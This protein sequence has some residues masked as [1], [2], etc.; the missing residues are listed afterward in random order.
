MKI[1]NLDNIKNPDVFYLWN[2][3]YK[4]L[5]NDD[6]K[7]YYL[8]NILSL[9]SKFDNTEKLKAIFKNILEKQN[10]LIEIKNE[11]IIWLFS[12]FNSKYL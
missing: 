12:Y 2:N 11:D 6:D 4:Y 8:K 1:I 7:K 3:E 9:D 10:I 5:E